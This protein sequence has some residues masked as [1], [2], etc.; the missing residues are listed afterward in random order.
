MQTILISLW[1]FLPAG[2]AN[3]AP[4]LVSKLPYL[5][6]Y[7]FPLDFFCSF[8]GKRILGDHKTIR[9]LIAGTVE[10]IIVVY[11]QAYLSMTNNFFN[12]V[13]II[14]YKSANLIV[15]GFLFG[16]GALGGDIVKSFFKRR[17]LIDSGKSWFFFDQSDYIIGGLIF[18]ALYIKIPLLYLINIYIIWF[19][20]HILFS[21]V[22]YLLKLKDAPL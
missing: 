4:I 16:F 3:V 5:K 18:T 17:F 15:L 12:S 7:S 14:D 20:M 9:G 10:A 8:R 6:K 1:Y 11:I 13:S 2:C 19:L 22:G 21:A